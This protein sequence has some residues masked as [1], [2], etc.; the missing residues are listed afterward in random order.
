M[1]GTK[2]SQKPGAGVPVG[3]CV[4]LRVAEEKEGRCDSPGSEAVLGVGDSHSSGSFCLPGTQA[5]HEEQE[6][7]DAHAVG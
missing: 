6:S 5:Q 3:G 2:L 1:G 7:D 4:T